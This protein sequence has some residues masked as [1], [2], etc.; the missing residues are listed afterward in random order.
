MSIP[1]N[2]EKPSELKRWACSV[3]IARSLRSMT[4][5]FFTES[6]EP[7]SIDPGNLQPQKPR[8]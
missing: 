5:K 6:T 1:N 7:L 4:I 3:A 2:V 8:L